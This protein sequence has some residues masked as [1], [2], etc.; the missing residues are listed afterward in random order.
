VCV[1]VYY[2]LLYTYIIY[3]YVIQ[4]NLKQYKL[5]CLDHLEVRTLIQCNTL[6]S[7]YK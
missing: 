1:Y 5:Y 4:F 2:N 3:V 6:R 7:N